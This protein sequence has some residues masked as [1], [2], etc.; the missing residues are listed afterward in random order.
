MVMMSVMSMLVTRLRREM[1]S[2]TPA[3]YQ[4]SLKKAVAIFVTH[5]WSSLGKAAVGIKIVEVNGL[6]KCTLGELL[7]LRAKQ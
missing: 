6:P 1:S 5:L 2:P 4:Y 7:R 3:C